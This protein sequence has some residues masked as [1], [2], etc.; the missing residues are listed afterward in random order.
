MTLL[1]TKWLGRLFSSLKRSRVVITS[2]KI[3]AIIC[4]AHF[5]QLAGD[6]PIVPR[7]GQK[8]RPTV[9]AKRGVRS[10]IGTFETCQ[11]ALRMSVYRGGAEVTRRL[12]K[13]RD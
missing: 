9:M 12:P 11:P 8:S 7:T 2:S 1:L 5:A 10:E 4:L 13:Q 6:K 3:A